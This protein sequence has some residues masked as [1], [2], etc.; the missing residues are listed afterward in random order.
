[1]SKQADNPQIVLF[2]S[3][4]GA[5]LLDVPT[6]VQTVWLSQDQMATLFDT[7]K[8]NVSFHIGNCFKEGELEKG[9]VVK[10][11]LTTA[12][13]GKTYKVKYYNLD[14]I[15]SVGYRVKSKRGVEFR[16]WAT[17]VLRRYII[18]G[19]AENERRLQQLSQTVALL[20]RVS[21]D[22]DAEQVLEVVKAYAPALD[23]LDDYDR[24]RIARPS[25]TDAV[26]MLEY[27]EC[28]DLIAALKFS[29]ESN[30]FGVEKELPSKAA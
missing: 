7:T 6:D 11:S 5:V 4:D 16:R 10:D 15:I 9:S 17:D 21:G 27:D 2:E 24:Q 26:Y 28:C 14:V 8:Q 20:E 13:D 29:N 1:M 22:L 25:G 12:A 3:S 19:R 30:L 18:D 23:L